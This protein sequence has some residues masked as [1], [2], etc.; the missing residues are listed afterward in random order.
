VD[1]TD[2]FAGYPAYFRRQNAAPARFAHEKFLQLTQVLNDAA[3]SATR[4]GLDAAFDRP[5]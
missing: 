5:L 3:K 1:Y 2:N 4:G